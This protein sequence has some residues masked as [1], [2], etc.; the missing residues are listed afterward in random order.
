MDGALRT[1]RMHVYA[2]LHK[3]PPVPELYI[4]NWAFRRLRQENGKFKSRRLGIQLNST[5]PDCQAQDS[6][7]KKR[8]RK[9]IPRGA[10]SVTPVLKL[11]FTK[12][13]GNVP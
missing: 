4:V 10:N 13:A 6:R 8:K 5:A 7:T 12:R 2:A 11:K 3:Y 9:K 1:Y